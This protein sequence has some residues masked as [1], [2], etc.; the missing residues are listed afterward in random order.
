MSFFSSMLSFPTVIYSF[1][2]CVCVILWLLTALGMLGFE[3]ADA[4]V[5][6]VGGGLDHHI[7]SE[8][9][10]LLSRFG[11]NG[12]PIT[13]MVTLLALFGWVISFLAQSLILKHFPGIFYY[14]AGLVVFVVSFVAT[15][16]LTAK[17]CRPLRVVF[18]SQSAP[19]NQ[20][21]I[22][23]VVTVSSLTVDPNYGEAFMDDGGAGL[24][25]QIRAESL[26]QLK[27]GDKVVLLEYLHDI[28]AYRVI[29]EDEF[30][31]I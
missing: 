8:A 25:L 29:S 14:L 20:H 2:L 4:D 16:F 5:S 28:S 1:F 15:V 13:L 10:G 12:V 31:G 11:L 21:L 17:V 3:G 27:K 9:M 30:K 24:L 22:G 6:G 26:Q 23:H 7:A 18:K 19:R